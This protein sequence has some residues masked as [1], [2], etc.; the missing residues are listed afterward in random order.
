MAAAP[1]PESWFFVNGR[2]NIKI[3]GN[4]GDYILQTRATEDA[5]WTTVEGLEQ[6]GGFVQT[7]TQEYS[8]SS[9]WRLG[10]NTDAPEWTEP[11]LLNARY[12]LLDGTCIDCGAFN[13]DPSVAGDKAFDGRPSTF[14]DPKTPPLYVGKDF[15]E[16][17]A[18]G[19]I[20]YIPRSGWGKRMAG[21]YIEY[22]DSADFSPSTK[23]QF[24]A[25]DETP[26][27]ELHTFE[28]PEVITARYV[29]FSKS[30]DDWMNIAELEFS[31]PSNEDAPETADLADTNLHVDGRRTDTEYNPVLKWNAVEAPVTLEV[32]DS[33]QGPWETL[34]KIRP[35]VSSYE[36]AA[37]P[38]GQHLYYRLVSG[39]FASAVV[40][41][42]RLRRI[43]TSGATVK[44]QGNEEA[45]GYAPGDYAFDG[46]ANTCPDIEYTPSYL[47]KI[48]INF[49]NTPSNH[50]ALVA[51]LPKNN[52]GQYGRLNGANLYGSALAL[53][54][55]IATDDLS[56]TLTEHAASGAQFSIWMTIPCDPTYCY[57]TYVIHGC[58][59]GNVAEVM[60]YGWYEG[61]D[62]PQEVTPTIEE[63]KVVPLDL[64]TFT[65]SLSWK[66]VLG[67]VRV[68]RSVNG[69]AWETLA[70]LAAL[71]G[72]YVDHTEFKVGTLLKY[73]IISSDAE[74]PVVSYRPMRR[75]EVD[76]DT[77]FATG[78]PWDEGGKATNAFD[79]NPNSRCDLW[80]KS[81]GGNDNDN[82]KLGVDFGNAT[83]YVGCIRFMAKHSSRCNGITLYGTNH[84]AET[85]TTTYEHSRDDSTKLTTRVATVPNGT[86]MYVMVNDL[87]EL[88]KAYRSYFVADMSEGGGG[89]LAEVEFYGWSKADQAQGLVITIR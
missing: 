18:I 28:F 50:I 19:S 64:T 53:D 3:G 48:A 82:I 46:N 87:S 12:P 85:E 21:G 67:Q 59:N 10:T 1:Q 35:H 43:P 6:N 75:L 20:A 71:N 74:S 45:W 68:M 25:D 24:V 70:T 30:D 15:G 56:T 61:E 58:E 13:D 47:P 40:S 31:E 5:E 37:G 11:Q 84:D 79:G 83:N 89:M 54:D 32:S 77:V 81:T 51:M 72:T 42:R 66:P 14:Y 41:G 8:G 63:F 62:V 4:A 29:R 76:I 57:P 52:S 55:E 33:D 17:V 78:E 69:G 60:F 23:I 36:V 86:W 7:P 73:Q 38:Y 16:Q 9:Y 39:P 2:L 80:W 34:A 88:A 44:W 49:G 65:P 26:T 27:Y 22:S